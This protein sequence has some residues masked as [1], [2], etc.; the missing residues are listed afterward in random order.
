MTE[1]P[2]ENKTLRHLPSA[3]QLCTIM[4]VFRS[5]RTSAHEPLGDDDERPAKRIST[6]AGQRLS[7]ILESTQARRSKSPAAKKGAK[8]NVT[9]TSTYCNDP[10]HQHIGHVHPAH[11]T[12][13]RESSRLGVVSVLTGGKLSTPRESLEAKT[14]PNGSALSVNVWS[15]KDSEKFGHVQ[16]RTSGGIFSRWSRKKMAIAGAMLLAFI[17]ALAV[18]LAFGLKKKSSE[19][20]DSTTMHI[21][22]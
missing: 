17:I 2:W 4:D 7:L 12:S 10:E 11:R 9:T 22:Q 16:H 13:K 8:I 19:R 18:G 20:Y 6:P 14:T 21:S 1:T 15:D 3:V 5:K